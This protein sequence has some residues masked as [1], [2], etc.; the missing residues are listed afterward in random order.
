MTKSAFPK[1]M[2][3]KVLILFFLILGMFLD[4]SAQGFARNRQIHD[5]LEH[6]LHMAKDDTSRVNVM[7]SMADSYS[8]S[9][10]D[11]ALY[12]GL[13]AAILARRIKYPKGEQW[14]L[15]YIGF[16]HEGLGNFPEAMHAYLEA[17]NVAEKSGIVDAKGFVLQRVGFIYRSINDFPK[18]L[19]YTSESIGL[20]DSLHSFELS[21][22][23]Q[24]H[25]ADIYSDLNRL[26]SAYY[27]ASLA[28]DNMNK[29]KS[30][31]LRTQTL[32]FLGNILKKKG[33]TAEA[34]KFFR[35]AL[36][37][38]YAD[39]IEFKT[40]NSAHEIAELHQLLNDPDSAIYYAKKSLA[41]AQRK[42]L[43]SVIIK[44]SNILSS[45]YQDKDPATALSYSKIAGSAKD[46]A[47][48]VEKKFALQNVVGFDMQ[49]RKFEIDAAK[50]AYEN[51]VR[52]F[53]LTSSLAVFL[54]IVILLYRNYRLKH[55][56]N[57]VLQKTLA[58]LK[59]TQAQLIQSEKMASLGELT[60]GI[61]HEIKNPLN[62]VNNFSDLA[63]ELLAELKTGPLDNLPSAQKEKALELVNGAIESLQKVI[64]H[65]K[66]ADG[67]VKAMLQHSRPSSGHK[68]LTD[69]NALA[70]EYL[71]LSYHGLQ[72]KDGNFQ[73]KIS[74]EFD[75]N[76]GR[77]YVIPEDIGRVFQN[78]YTNALYSVTLKKR[79]LKD[80][81]IPSI[82]VSTRKFDEKIEVHIRDNGIG[83]PQRIIDKIFKPFF[84]TKP[85]GEGTGLGLSLSYD[86]MKAHGGDIRVESTEGEGAEFTI[87]I[88]AKMNSIA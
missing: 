20:L 33:N 51:K 65:G 54:I 12:Y 52:M 11:S 73:A 87:E 37:S 78:L 40:Y 30:E 82:A 34:M 16:T 88:P 50:T 64:L 81:F 71:R 59:A 19:H 21:I 80:G 84:T 66:R 35:Q 25:L 22:V 55:R 72:A 79:Q 68:E 36:A 17:L 42:H 26:D 28:Y 6:L 29:Y 38:A 67:I 63:N 10:P 83:I 58:N 48:M 60:A 24:I 46:S 62:F 57:Q 15:F 75:K 27:F 43:Y 69:I 77:I 74:T 39:T 85:T 86:V 14:A 4:G 44:A 41:E 61:G 32:F 70:D 23:S 9:E 56:S 49:E 53:I 31:M 76:I 18:A 3:R 13:K 2:V 8:F 45:I 1:S 5:S 7:V 47:S